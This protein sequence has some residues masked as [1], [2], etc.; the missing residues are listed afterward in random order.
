MDESTQPGVY[1]KFDDTDTDWVA[2]GEDAI[3]W[4]VQP[5]FLGPTW[6]KDPT[7]K[8]PRTPDGYILPEFTLGWQVIK[9]IENNLLADETGPDDKPLPLQ[10]TPEQA[11][12][13]LWFYAVDKNGRF[14][15][16][17]VVFQRLKGHGKDPIA[18]CIAAVE[19]VG[20]CRFAGWAMHDQP[21]DGIEKGDPVGKPHPRAW[22]QIAAV[23]LEQTN[24]TM[25]LFQGQFTHECI[26]KHSIDLG[27]QTIYAYGGKKQIKAVTSN[28]AALEGNRPTLVIKNETHHWGTGVDGGIAMADAI[29]RN[30]TKAKGGAA[31]TLSITN[32][33]EP[34]QDTVARR[35]R[36]AYELLAAGAY[37]GND[38]LY[39]SLEAPKDARL[40]PRFPDEADGAERRGVPIIDDEVK[41]R[42][43]RKYLSRVLEAV[44][45]DS[46]WLDI[47]S[48]TSSILNP[49]NKAS[50]SRRFWF[51]QITANEDAWVRPEAV[52]AAIS[53]LA[54]EARQMAG[55]MGREQIEAGWLV[56]PGEP[57]VMFGD[58]SKN[59]DSTALVG[60]SLVTGYTFLIGVWQKPPGER[61]KT[62]LAPRNAVN[63]RV[64]VAFERFN[65][66]AFWF[67]PSHTKDD[68]DDSSYWMPSLD[69]W[70]RDYKD[71]LPSTF[72]PIK[73]GPARHAINF[74]M[75]GAD[76]M[77]LFVAGAE[78]FIE[79]IE[80]V[81]DIEEFASTFEICGHP[82]L[83]AHLQNA[84]QHFSM[85][86]WGVSLTKEAPDSPNKIDAAVCAVGARMLSRIVL[87]LHEEEEVDQPGEIW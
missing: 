15:Y 45:G 67:D 31:R 55:S 28:P 36:Q 43:T 73:S 6:S 53:A 30:A 56:A 35:E 29:E 20:P 59:D 5:F 1:A 78:Q 12:F 8:G 76:R 82:V 23:S 16:R 50:R 61:G 22:V 34:S 51:N 13:V 54:R 42:L 17:E 64:K 71:Q 21:D 85:N 79:D 68:T 66:Q 19:F 87:N 44:R 74:D 40:R 37:D 77:K 27:K 41:H 52:E 33:Y 72:W 86:G 2:L 70:M 49:K 80:T 14:L 47:P 39:D 11:R 63:E 48:L 38:M 81:N 58:G 18:A 32:A 46:W 26:V 10:L 62:W 7:W 60:T 84:V 65:I 75:T 3:D 83:V 25:L 24:N 9:W 69:K 57:I 4:E